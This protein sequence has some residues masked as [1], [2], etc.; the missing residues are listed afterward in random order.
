MLQDFVAEG[1]EEEGLGG[2]FAD[3]AGAD[4][5]ESLFVELA[6]GAAVG[7]FDIVVVDFEEGAGVDVRFVGE[8]YVFVGLIGFGFGGA[9]AD[10]DVPV[11]GGAGG[12]VED[13]FEQFAAVAFGAG[14]V[15]EDV[16][17]DLLLLVVEEEAV[18]LD[19]AVGA[20][21][22]YFGVVADVAAVE[23]HGY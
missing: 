1:V 14:V 12:V 18:G 19:V 8:E 11:E 4:V 6:Y 7:A 23:C 22:G 5:E 3:A 2:A 13:A 20:E 15:D 17:V 9:V 21:H 16:V 10:E